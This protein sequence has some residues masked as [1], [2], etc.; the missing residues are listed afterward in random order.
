MATDLKEDSALDV[1]VCLAPRSNSTQLIG[2]MRSMSGGDSRVMS[3]RISNSDVKPKAL[4][5][6]TNLDSDPYKSEGLDERRS[7]RPWIVV[8]AGLGTGAHSKEKK[9]EADE[10]SAEGNVSARMKWKSAIKECG[11]DRLT[12]S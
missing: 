7:I 12:C 11:L 6:S 1:G 4:N 9:M 2:H 8:Q 5:G 3:V 10:G